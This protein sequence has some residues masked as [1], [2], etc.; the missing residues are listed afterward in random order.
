MCLKLLAVYFAVIILIPGCTSAPAPQREQNSLKPEKSSPTVTVY[1][2]EPSKFYRDEYGYTGI[3]YS[4]YTEQCEKIKVLLDK[5]NAMPD[6][7]KKET[8]RLSRFGVIVFHIGRQD[9]MHANTRWYNFTATKNSRTLFSINGEEGIPNIKGR[10][11]N[12][13]NIVE[14]PLTEEITSKINITVKDKKTGK[15]FDFTV[16]KEEIAQQ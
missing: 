14:I 13:W 16:I 8:A 2:V 1:R 15:E 4:T 7:Y 5:K 11:G 10:D 12:W 3:G 6:E 9:L